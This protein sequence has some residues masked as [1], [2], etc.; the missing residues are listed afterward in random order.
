MNWYHV[1]FMAA[2]ATPSTRPWHAQFRC[3]VQAK[4]PVDAL[5]VAVRERYGHGVVTQWVIEGD[6]E[7]PTLWVF[8]DHFVLIEEEDAVLDELVYE[9]TPAEVMEKMGVPTL[10][11]TMGTDSP[12]FVGL[13]E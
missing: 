2:T 12:L 11:D 3:D 5:H 4:S 7:I 6:V 9:L 13:G 10:F 8:E 1:D